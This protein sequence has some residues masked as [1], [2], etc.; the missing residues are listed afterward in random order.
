MA[1]KADLGHFQSASNL[2]NSYFAI[3]YHH[4]N[5]GAFIKKCTILSRSRWTISGINAKKCSV[6]VYG[7]GV[8]KNKHNMLN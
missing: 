7:E 6:L 8:R 1:A 5:F 2:S 3:N 4:T